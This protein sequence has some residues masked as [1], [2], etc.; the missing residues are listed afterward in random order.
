MVNRHRTF[1]GSGTSEGHAAKELRLDTDF[2]FDGPPDE[3]MIDDVE[4][5][6]TRAHETSV[7]TVRDALMLGYFEPA[8]DC[9]TDSYGA[10]EQ[11]AREITQ[12]LAIAAVEG[13]DA[14]YMEEI[15]AAAAAVTAK[16]RPT[17]EVHIRIAGRECSVEVQPRREKTGEDSG[18]GTAHATRDEPNWID[19]TEEMSERGWLEEQLGLTRATQDLAEREPVKKGAE[20]RDQVRKQKT[21]QKQWDGLFMVLRNR[22]NPKYGGTPDWIGT[23]AHARRARAGVPAMTTTK[24]R[25][26]LIQT[27]L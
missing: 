26:S 20:K 9:G 12:T 7:S 5:V 13:D 4:I 2:V 27:D 23:H 24:Q 18:S 14:A 3:V 19:P 8:D 21:L 16:T 22:T 25:R 1:D 11:A 15:H 17:D 10:Q 6:V